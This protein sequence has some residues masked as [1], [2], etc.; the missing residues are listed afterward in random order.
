MA[1]KSNIRY[2]NS[3][4]INFIA[5][6]IGMM[7]NISRKIQSSPIHMYTYMYTWNDSKK[8]KAN[9]NNGIFHYCRE[10]H[11]KYRSDEIYAKM[12][13]WASVKKWSLCACRFYACACILYC[14]TAAVWCNDHCWFGWKWVRVMMNGQSTP[15]TR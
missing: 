10:M 9:T 4:A 1:Q 8:A 5:N 15:L 3:K 12:Y 13:G 7:F 6:K 14:S 11:L 2:R